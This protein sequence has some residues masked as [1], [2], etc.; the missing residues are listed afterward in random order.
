MSE[1]KGQK[2]HI[3]CIIENDN[4]N[5]FRIG[6]SRNLKERLCDLNV[7]TVIY[8]CKSKDLN[9][10]INKAY[11]YFRH[12]YEQYS[13]VEYFTSSRGINAK[14]LEKELREIFNEVR[15]VKGNYNKL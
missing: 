4:D 3:F 1:T 6:K 12:K 8:V 15:N 5:V 14:I 13:G 2:G 9:S 11:E 7:K 10:D